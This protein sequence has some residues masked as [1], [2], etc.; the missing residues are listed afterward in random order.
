MRGALFEPRTS[1]AHPRHIPGLRGLQRRIGGGQWFFLRSKSGGQT[2]ADSLSARPIVKPDMADSRDVAALCVQWPA[3][4]S[5]AGDQALH[6]DRLA[7]ATQVVQ[8]HGGQVDPASTQALQAIFGGGSAQADHTDHTD[9]T[10][11]AVRCGLALLDL[12]AAGAPLRMGVHTGPMAAHLAACLAHAAPPGR[13]RLS[14]QAAAQVRER[15]DIEVPA[16]LAVAGLQMPLHAGLLRPARLQS[17]QPADDVRTPLVGRQPELAALQAAFQRLFD[18]RHDSCQARALTV[19]AEPGIGKSRLLREFAAWAQAQPVAFHVLRGKASP[20]DEG[21]P[22]GL[23]GGLLRSFCQIDG[24]STSEAARARLEQA[25]VPWFMPW[26]V[27]DE[28]ADLAESQAHVLGHLIGIDFADSRHLQGLLSAPQQIRQLAFNAAAQLL[29]RLSAAGGAPVLL[30]IEDLHW[31]DSDTLDFLDHLLK[32]NHDIAMLI[33]STARPTLSD[34]RP[35]WARSAGPHTRLN[36]GPLDPAAGQ[37]LAAQLLKRLPQIPPA[38]LA[39]VVDATQGNPFCIE[40]RVRLLIDLG[41]IQAGI[42]DWSVSMAK[43]RAAKLPKTL[44]GVLTARLNLLPAAERR[45]LQ[46]ASVIGPVFLQGALLALG[47]GAARAMRGLMQRELTL[48]HAWVGAAGAAAGDGAAQFSF[49]HQLLQQLAY[50]TLPSPTRR[51]LHGKLARWLVTLTGPQASEV[52]GL[53]AHHFEQAGDDEQAAAQ[54]TRAAEHAA[55]RFALDALATHAQRGLALLDTLAVSPDRRELRWRLLRMRTSMMEHG[56][57]GAQLRADLDAQSALAEELADDTKRALAGQRQSQLAMLTADFAGMK[58]AALHTMACAARADQQALRLAA[59][60]TL[61]LAHCYLR[62]WDAGLRL[63]Q[64]CLVQARELGLLRIEAA[65][66]NT[67]SMVAQKR[68]DPVARLRWNEQALPLHQQL[69]DR[70]QT[71]IALT[72]LGDGWLELGELSVGRR[73]CEEA[74]RLA[75]AVGHR[76]SECH[77]L[78][79]LSKLERWLGNGPQAL[80]LARAALEAALALGVPQLEQMALKRLG[81]AQWITGDRAAAAEAFEQARAQALKHKM[82]QPDDA[83]AG[84]ARLAL[85]DGD[86]AGA[87]R[88][89]QHV[90]DRAAASGYAHDAEHPHQVD[91]VCHLVL[92]SAGDP[93]A[94]AW[95]QRAH[96]QLLTV[97]ATISDASLREGFLNNIPDHRAILAAWALHEQEVAADPGT[98]AQ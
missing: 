16:P 33:V 48:A 53:T 13:L 39:R 89:V 21:Q 30:Q 77:A 3:N 8:A 35:A 80:A 71:A 75:T 93:R 51:T 23:L 55:S 54:H 50:D 5:R 9:H 96:G 65:C 98:L 32:A 86:L 64:Q 56:S 2:G 62:D 79:N 92:S 74:L 87:L 52:L 12:A 58:A 38:L 41:V 22:F 57:Q 67:L 15:F 14:L 49:K 61:A 66:M 78:C 37:Q 81:N 24:D 4:E 19:L 11:R 69:D 34:R 90:L 76:F 26:F 91:L 47:A 1:P 44:A 73:Y 31:A 6:C 43:L 36:L 10:E 88:Q 7:S 29:R 97:A 40:E 59:L 27:Q 42:G 28:G 60:R 68:Q 95:L 84:L 72:N 20:Q 82:A 83:S 25:I 70:R 46:Q 94:D 45:A 18:T 17:L 85:A 63:A